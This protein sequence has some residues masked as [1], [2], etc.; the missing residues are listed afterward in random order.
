M[1]PGPH[2]LDRVVTLEKIEQETQTRGVVA[3]ELDARS[4]AAWSRA[5]RAEP[6]A[7]G[8]GGDAEQRQSARR[9][10]STSPP[11]RSRKSSSAITNP[12]SVPRITLSLSR[13]V[14]D[15]GWR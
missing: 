9:V 11:P 2:Q 5:L 6:D 10:P 13:A 12:S 15:K 8:Q 1:S 3:L 4:V 14:S 7:F